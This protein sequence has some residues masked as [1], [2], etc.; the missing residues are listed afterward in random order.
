MSVT[1][2]VESDD[3]E[4]DFLSLDQDLH[5]ASIVALIANISNIDNALFFI[6]ISSHQ[7]KFCP[8]SGAKRGKS[9]FLWLA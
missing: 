6:I 1:P 5:P 8:F 9:D 2:P 4:S 7:Q 3:D